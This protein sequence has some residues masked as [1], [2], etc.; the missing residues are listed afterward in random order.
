MEIMAVDLLTNKP[1]KG[2]MNVSAYNSII[3]REIKA[4]VYGKRQTS[5]SCISFLKID[6]MHTRIV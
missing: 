4:R 5:E 3:V 2:E 1:F 6:S